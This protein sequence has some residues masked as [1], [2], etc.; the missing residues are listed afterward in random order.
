[1]IR[2]TKESE[3]A[4]LLLSALLDE[5]DVPKS[6][7]KLAEQTGI[8]APMTGK[9]LKRLV[10]YDILAS[11]RGAYGGYTLTRAPEEV[12]V[13]EVV[14]AMEGAPELVDCVKGGKDC[15][16]APRCRISPFW[17]SVNHDI[18]DMLAAKTLLDMQ[19]DERQARRTQ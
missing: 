16:F 14:E 3:Y 9:V 5:D 10:K 7:S 11:T 2:I 1:M 4:F 12:S 6:A 15:A 19:R 17:L 13:L 8:A 18:R